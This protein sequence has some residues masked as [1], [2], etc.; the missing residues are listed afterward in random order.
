MFF[1]Q[2]LFTPPGIPTTF[3]LPPGIFHYPQQ[4]VTFFG[5]AQF[6]F[7]EKHNIYS[8]WISNRIQYDSL[9]ISGKYVVLFVLAP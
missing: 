8:S 5:K 7:L 2:F 6:Y 3:T 4:G 1:P 9:R